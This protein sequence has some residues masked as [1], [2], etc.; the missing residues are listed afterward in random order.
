MVPLA[1]NWNNLINGNDTKLSNHGRVRWVTKIKKIYLSI[2][3][4]NQL[5]VEKEHTSDRVQVAVKVDWIYTEVRRTHG[6]GGQA[7]NC[8]IGL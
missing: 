1:E 6:S 5:T 8:N 2:R 3:Q 4:M 7:S